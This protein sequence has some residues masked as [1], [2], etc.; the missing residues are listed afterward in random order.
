MK[1]LNESYAGAIR[2]EMIHWLEESQKFVV[3]PALEEQLNKLCCKAYH[4]HEVGESYL[5]WGDNYSPKK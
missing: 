4:S 5:Q 3:Y 1:C 2:G